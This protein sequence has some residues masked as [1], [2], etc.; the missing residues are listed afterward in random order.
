MD[1][2]GYDTFEPTAPLM[3]AIFTIRETIPEGCES[4]QFDFNEPGVII[5]L[6]YL[7]DGSISDKSVELTEAQ[8][9]AGGLLL[10][11]ISYQLITLTG[12]QESSGDEAIF[13]AQ[14]R[15][16]ESLAEVGLR[17]GL[18]DES[19]TDTVTISR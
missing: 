7:P 5:A 2:P 11:Y 13:A 12:M 6:A 19:L 14:T 8:K 18:L 3:H 17:I 10:E 9:G 16:R 15:L 4:V 1:F